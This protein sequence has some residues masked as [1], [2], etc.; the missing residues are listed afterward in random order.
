MDCAPLTSG[1]SALPGLIP[2][3]LHVSKFGGTTLSW[4][5]SEQGHASNVYRRWTDLLQAPLTPTCLL[6]ETAEL[7]LRDSLF[8]TSGTAFYY[9]VVACNYCGEGPAGLYGTGLDRA[10][11]N[12]CPVVDD[13]FDL[14]GLPNV[15][16]NCSTYPNPGQWDYDLDF[17]GDVCD[18]C[19]ATYNPD[20]ADL[21]G[22]SYGDVCD[23]D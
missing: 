6:S 2:T 22:D 15:A 20:Q 7:S 10:I 18:N 14:D 21:D 9:L 5:R 4:E 17:V 16:D 12:P 23:P 1:V 8:P 13:D 3:T 19:P 11:T